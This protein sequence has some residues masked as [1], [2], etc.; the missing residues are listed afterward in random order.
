MAPHIQRRLEDGPS[1]ILF[2]VVAHEH[3]DAAEIDLGV[4]FDW[5]IIFHVRAAMFSALLRLIADVAT[6][7]SAD[8]DL[9]CEL[10]NRDGTGHVKVSI[11]P[12]IERI[13]GGESAPRRCLC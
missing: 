8:I 3:H 2:P 9:G 13:R 10:S 7:E 5:R 6:D 11:G 4:P 12:L 1:L